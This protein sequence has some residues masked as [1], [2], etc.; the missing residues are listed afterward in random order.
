MR[1]CLES[2]CYNAFPINAWGR[3]PSRCP[4]CEAKRKAA[5]KRVNWPAEV[6]PRY[7]L[8]AWKRLRERILRERPRCEIRLPGCTGRAT[9][10]D[11]IVSANVAPDRFLDPT[12]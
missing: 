12:N 7:R 1:R 2:G 11:H 9:S 10:V 3:N 6:D 4:E 8:P 5:G